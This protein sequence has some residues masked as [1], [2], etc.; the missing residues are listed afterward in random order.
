M[1]D[2]QKV[3]IELN[4]HEYYLRFAKQGADEQVF[5]TMKDMFLAGAFMGWKKHQR[6]PLKSRRTIFGWEQFDRE[7]IALVQSLALAMTDSP[8]VL[9]DRDE[10]LTIV[11]EYANAGIGELLSVLHQPGGALQALV[12]LGLTAPLYEDE[13]RLAHAARVV[14]HFGSH[15]DEYEPVEILRGGGMAD[16][17]HVRASDGGRDLF[18]KRV[19]TDDGS[20]DFKAL[21]RELDIYR[22]LMD[23]PADY[24]LEV[25]DVCRKGPY[26]ALVTE[27]ADGGT[28]EAYVL[29]QASRAVSTQEAFEIS[30]E[31]IA[32]LRYLHEKDV[33]HRDLKPQNVLRCGEKW[34]LADFG[35]SKSR[36]RFWTAR[37]FRGYATLGYAPPEQREGIEAKPSADIYALGKVITFMLTGVTDIDRIENMHWARLV[38]SCVEADPGVRPALERLEESLEELPK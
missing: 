16:A 20:A 7:D 36:E 21:Q 11:E 22:R 26:T 19:R 38:R 34:K 9:I 18:L 2:R 37:T 17:F 14:E 28:L 5:G 15:F 13:A 8:G 23:E 25:V 33:V 6:R 4:Y 31:I 24:L 32:G 10:V 12:E 35:I 29:G 27:W 30:K 3:N 1:P